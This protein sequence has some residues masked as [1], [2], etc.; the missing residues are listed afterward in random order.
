MGITLGVSVSKANGY[1]TYELLNAQGELI[2]FIVY[3]P[4]G[5]A[6]GCYSN[7]E[8]ANGRV[9]KLIKIDSEELELDPVVEVN[10]QKP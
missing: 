1:S 6:V 10:L 3:N 9:S 8:E 2:G 5:I 4:S 7:Q